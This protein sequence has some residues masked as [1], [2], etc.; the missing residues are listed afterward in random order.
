MVYEE[1]MQTV[2]RSDPE[3]DL[4]FQDSYSCSAVD[5]ESSGL[6]CY[7]LGYCVWD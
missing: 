4:M 1:P 2:S 7:A 5:W 3:S 6:H